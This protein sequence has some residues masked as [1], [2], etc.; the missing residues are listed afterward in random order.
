[1]VLDEA[2]AEDEHAQRAA[3]GGEV[4]DRAD[5]LRDVDDEAGV[6]EGVEVFFPPRY[7]QE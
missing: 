3:L 2:A 4:V 7:R 1:M 5:V 6:F